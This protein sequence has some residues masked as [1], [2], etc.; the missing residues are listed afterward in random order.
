MRSLPGSIQVAFLYHI[1]QIVESGDLAAISN[2]I[3]LGFSPENLDKLR[4]LPSMEIARLISDDK[5]F[6]HFTVDSIRIDKAFRGLSQNKKEAEMQ[7]EFIRCGASAS[8]MFQLFRMSRKQVS[9]QRALLCVKRED[10]RPSLPS[11]EL[12]HK[13][14]KVWKTL[15][16]SNIRQRYLALHEEFPTTSLAVLY[17]VVGMDQERSG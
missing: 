12:Q 10:G 3:D 17:A 1:I 7:D 11:E 8:M 2:L 6:M 15:K 5:P 9:A 16:H 14:Y 13:I 4:H